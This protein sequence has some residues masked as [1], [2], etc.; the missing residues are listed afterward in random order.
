MINKLAWERV[1]ARFERRRP[2]RKLSRLWRKRRRAA[3]D[4][5]G[6]QLN[7][8]HRRCSDLLVLDKICCSEG[9][10][11]KFYVGNL[12]K[13]VENLN[14]PCELSRVGR[15]ALLSSQYSGSPEGWPCSRLLL[16]V[17]VHLWFYSL[18]WMKLFLSLSQ[19]S[20]QPEGWPCSRLLFMSIYCVFLIY[21]NHICNCMYFDVVKCAEFDIFVF[22]HCCICIC[23]LLLV[24][25]FISHFQYRSARGLQLLCNIS[26]KINLC[27]YWLFCLILQ[28]LFGLYLCF[29]QKKFQ[30]LSLHLP[31]SIF[32][33]L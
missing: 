1:R 18:L 26:L 13:T 22:V 25:F 2:A 4:Y 33:P 28:K 8:F 19:Y 15:A 32:C 14:K 9:F 10:L 21:C 5:L 23:M 3:L 27:L 24:V 11:L 6:W 7:N 16:I 29:M 12:E 30:T 31:C 17:F 20:G